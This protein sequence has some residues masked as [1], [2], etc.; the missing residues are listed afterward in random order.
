MGD[1]TRFV[2][3]EYLSDPN[4]VC[5][6]RLLAFLGEAF[7]SD[8]KKLQELI[9]V[10]YLENLFREKNNFNGIQKRLSHDMSI[11]LSKYD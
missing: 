10:F 2:E 7:S 5:I 8:D 3:A 6:K 4:S 11:E 1:V 9:S